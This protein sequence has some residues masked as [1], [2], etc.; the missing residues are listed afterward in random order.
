MPATPGRFTFARLALGM[1]LVA[2]PLTAHAQN[3][4]VKPQGQEIK[5]K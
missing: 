5:E 2:L 1:V 4:K 3:D